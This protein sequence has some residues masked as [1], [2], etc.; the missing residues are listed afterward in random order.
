MVRPSPVPKANKTSVMAQAATAPATI[1]GQRHAH[2]CR[3]ERFPGA[4]TTVSIIGTC[5]KNEAHNSGATAATMCRGREVLK[6]GTFCRLIDL[7]ACFVRLH[8]RDQREV[9]ERTFAPLKILRR[10]S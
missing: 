4:T 9:D 8:C 10:F 1:A 7:P 6:V 2:E 5:S 3:A